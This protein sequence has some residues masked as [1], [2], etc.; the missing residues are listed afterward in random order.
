[1]PLLILIGCQAPTGPVLHRKRKLC[2]TTYT[3]T[4][5]LIMGQVFY[6]TDSWP[7]WPIHISWPIW[8]MTHDPLTHCL[9]WFVVTRHADLIVNVFCGAY[10]IRV[11][12]S[13]S[14][15]VR[16]CVSVSLRLGNL[17]NIISHKPMMGFHQILVTGI[18]GFVDVL[19]RFWGQKVQGKCFWCRCFHALLFVV[20]I[21]LPPFVVNTDD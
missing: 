11:C 2:L 4:R 9:L 3:F 19:I 8:P 6:G 21:S 15:W 17:V 18:F 5:H 20:L 13:A 14:E 1:M 10:S 16:V 7:T 12:P